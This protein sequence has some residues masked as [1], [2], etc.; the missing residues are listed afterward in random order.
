MQ[1]RLVFEAKKASSGVDKGKPAYMR[2]TTW[3]SA[4]LSPRPVPGLFMTCPPCCGLFYVSMQAHTDIPSLLSSPYS[5]EYS[6]TN[7][8]T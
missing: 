3:L 6:A 8:S 5:D 7:E 2:L 1:C 4:N